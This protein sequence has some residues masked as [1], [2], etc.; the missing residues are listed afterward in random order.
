MGSA[1]PLQRETIKVSFSVYNFLNKFQRGL[2]WW[3]DK[4]PD[5]I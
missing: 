3:H 1:T 2:P 5:D 4:Y